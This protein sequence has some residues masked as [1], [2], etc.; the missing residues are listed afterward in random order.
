MATIPPHPHGGR[1]RGFQA[2]T[3]TGQWRDLLRHGHRR[4]FTAGTQLLAQGGVGTVVYAL[5]HGRTRVVYTEDNGDEALVAIRGPGDLLGEYAQRDRG[6]HMASVQ[7]LEKC[8]ATV[9]TVQ[10]FERCIRRHGLEE[11]LQRYM[12]GKARQ[13]GKRMWRAAH[14]NI[15]QRTARLFLEFIDAGPTQGASSIPMTQQELAAS[16]GVSR[17]SVAS[18]LGEWKRNGL[19]RTQPSPITV[20]DLPALTRKAIPH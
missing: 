4:V 18:L 12:L 19:V 2:I 1:A 15:E 17:R 7:T 14:L 5:T 13:I 10:T 11:A 3:T 20:L 6:E 8:V 16:L 9:M